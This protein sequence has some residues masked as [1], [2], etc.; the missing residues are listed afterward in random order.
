MEEIEEL[1]RSGDPRLSDAGKET[2]REVT[3]GSDLARELAALAEHDAELA[4]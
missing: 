4:G 3:R 1:R 2:L